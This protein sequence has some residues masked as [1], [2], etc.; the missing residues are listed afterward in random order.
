MTEYL[1]RAAEFYGT[2]FPHTPTK[3]PSGNWEVWVGN[4]ASEDEWRGRE[5]R[6]YWKLDGAVGGMGHLKKFITRDEAVVAAWRY[7]EECEKISAEAMPKS[8]P[9]SAVKQQSTGA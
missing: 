4:W 1:A 8:G 3:Q 2:C 5:A 9:E 7:K 6:A